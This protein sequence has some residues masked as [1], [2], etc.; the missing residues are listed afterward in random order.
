MV[1]LIVIATNIYAARAR[2]NQGEK[3]TRDWKPVNSTD[4]WRYMGCLLYIGESIEGKHE[5]Y[6]SSLHQMGR[7]L[8]LKRFEQIHRFFTLR[9]EESDP[10]RIE[11]S[12]AWKLDPIADLVRQNCRHNWIPSSHI[13]HRRGNG[14]LLRPNKSYHQNEE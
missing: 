3:C 2:Q 12:F 11:K 6:W 4:I 1:D 10:R 8:G 7:F 14:F 9:N 5:K 13:L